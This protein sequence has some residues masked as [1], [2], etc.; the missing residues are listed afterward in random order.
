M[1]IHFRDIN[2][3]HDEELIIEAETRLGQNKGLG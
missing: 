1:N 2:L 3:S